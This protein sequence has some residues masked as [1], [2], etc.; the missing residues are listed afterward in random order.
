MVDSC[1][2]LSFVLFKIS[3]I[4]ENCRVS[5]S[6]YLKKSHVEFSNG[7]ELD[8]GFVQKMGENDFDWFCVWFNGKD[9]IL[10][11]FFCYIE[12]FSSLLDPPK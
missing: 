3:V 6:L 12:S 2:F 9:K 5:L 8:M 1:L 11:W 4:L 7:G 10:K